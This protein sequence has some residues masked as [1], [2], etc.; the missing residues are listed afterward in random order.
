MAFGFL[1]PC[2]VYSLYGDDISLQRAV[3]IINNNIIYWY[4]Y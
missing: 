1:Y 2:E 3:G 4:L